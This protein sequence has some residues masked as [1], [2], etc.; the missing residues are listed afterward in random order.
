MLE[1]MNYI[2][3]VVFSVYGVVVMVV[4]ASQ[5]SKQLYFAYVFM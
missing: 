5:I 3:R 4:V 2:R 1:L